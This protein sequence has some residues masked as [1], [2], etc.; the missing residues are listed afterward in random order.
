MVSSVIPIEMIAK[1][2]WVCWRIT[3]RD[4][5]PTKMPIKSD[6]TGPASSTN[7]KTWGSYERA[8][9]AAANPKYGFAGVGF[10]LGDG[11]NG[12]DLDD[13]LVDGEPTPQAAEILAQ[14]SH[15]YAEISPSGNG[16]KIFGMDEGFNLP[17]E[18]TGTNTTKGIDFKKIEVYTADRFFTVTGNV[19][20]SS[21]S[22]LGDTTDALAWLIARY[23]PA[24][25][26]HPPR[27]AAISHCSSADDDTL[28]KARSFKTKNGAKFARVFDGDMSQYAGDQSAADLGLCSMLAFWCGRD[29][30]MMDRLFRRSGL[31]RDKWNEKRGVDTYG[32][33]TIAKAIEGCRDCYG[34]RKSSN[35]T[36]RAATPAPDFDDEPDLD[37]ETGEPIAEDHAADKPIHAVDGDGFPTGP[38]ILRYVEPMRI[39]EHFLARKLRDNRRRLLLRRWQQEFYRYSKSGFRYLAT[40]AIHEMLWQHIDQLWTPII[41]QKGDPT[42]E[43]SKLRLNKAVIADVLAALVGCGVFVD[44]EPPMWLDGGANRPDPSHLLSFTNGLL[45]PMPQPPVLMPSTPELFTLSSLDYPYNPVAP[46]PVEW[47]KFIGS[48]WPNDP[49]SIDLLGEWFGYCLTQLTNQQKALMLVGPPR[50]G[51]GTI[52]RILREMIGTANTCAPTLAGLSTNF[53]L[54]PMI[55]KQLAIISDARLSGRSDQAIVTERIL[56]ITGEDALTIDVKNQEPRTLTLKTR[57]MVLTNEL[58]RLADASGALANRFLILSLGES[59]LGKEDTGLF[60]RLSRELPGIL[61]WALEGLRRLQ[62]R[63]HFHPPASATER[64][65]EMMELSSPISGFIED[66]LVIDHSGETPAADAFKAWELWCAESGRQHAGDIQTF[67]RDLRSAM[68]AVRTIN[69]RAADGKRLRHYAGFRLTLST[70]EAVSIAKNAGVRHEN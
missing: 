27:P 64:L 62:A 1:N 50:A 28:D 16:I 6:N 15:T 59:H 32:A 46:A 58:P 45:N 23:W 22:T 69:R 12:V 10:V 49:L 21:P 63:G 29:A 14:F 65:A 35:S 66:S 17:D 44:G 67:G 43:V 33:I 8:V 48:L 38:N 40:D 26:T 7:P 57:L 54:W 19:F 25:P 51:K 60:D 20:G 24:K 30:G 5:K 61:L 11:F 31:M 52:A 18:K 3:D 68:P 2:R 36:T 37:D 70:A 41:D 47:M 55:G 53:G 34:D 39:A 56:S 9:A 4:G 42:G 13:C